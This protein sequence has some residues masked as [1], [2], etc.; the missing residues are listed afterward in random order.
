VC[1][2][3]LITGRIRF[4][5]AELKGEHFAAQ[6]LPEFG[7]ALLNLLPPLPSCFLQKIG[8]RCRHAEHLCFRVTVIENMQSGRYGYTFFTLGKFNELLGRSAN[9]DIALA[10]LAMT[11]VRAL[12]S[13]QTFPIQR[14]RG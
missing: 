13:C 14:A 5:P 2:S 9:M 4:R 8:P 10:D 6:L 12:G 7:G 11:H 3:S 1:G